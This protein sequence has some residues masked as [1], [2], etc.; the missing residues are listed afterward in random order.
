M[1]KPKEDYRI[2]SD[3]LGEVHVPAEAL[4]GTQ[5]K[6]ALDNFQIS[7]LRI[8]PSFVTAYAEIKKAA[9]EVNVRVGGLDGK[10][11]QA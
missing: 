6:R 3:P 5:T 1:D 7:S 10:I 4:Y 8:H 9:A 11:G 2:E